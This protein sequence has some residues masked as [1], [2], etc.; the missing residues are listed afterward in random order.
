[1]NSL[2]A[3]KREAKKGKNRRHERQSTG[4]DVKKRERHF[5]CLSL[6]VKPVIR[7][8]D[9]RWSTGCADFTHFEPECAQVGQTS[10]TQSNPVK[11]VKPVKPKK[12][13]NPPQTMKNSQIA[14]LPCS[15]YFAVRSLNFEL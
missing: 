11:P 10:Q 5:D 7:V 1:M 6:S 9:W 4:W 2:P 3:P 8:S 13:K 14:K 15:A 12:M